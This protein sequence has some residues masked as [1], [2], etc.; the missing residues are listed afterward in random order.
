MSD[1]TETQRAVEGTVRVER[2]ALAGGEVCSRARVRRRINGD[3]EV[4]FHPGC[5]RPREAAIVYV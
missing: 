3:V 2:M 1:F 4:Q 5:M